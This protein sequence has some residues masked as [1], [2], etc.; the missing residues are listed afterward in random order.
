MQT[1]HVSVLAFQKPRQRDPVPDL[2]RLHPGHPHWGGTLPAAAEGPQPA[3]DWGIPGQQQE[4]V[5][6]GRPGVSVGIS[7]PP[8]CTLKELPA[9]SAPGCISKP[10]VVL[11]A[12]PSPLFRNSTTASP[13]LASLNTFPTCVFHPSYHQFFHFSSFSG[14]LWSPSRSSA[15]SSGRTSDAG[16]FGG[17][18]TLWLG[19]HPIHI[20]YL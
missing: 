10:F 17:W 6:Q 8:P 9:D 2:P 3:D 5:Q 7:S 4:A 1:H 11:H 14:G 15:L 12:P 13:Y 18:E 19:S 20:K 16:R